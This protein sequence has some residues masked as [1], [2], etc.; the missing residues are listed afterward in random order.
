MGYDQWVEETLTEFKDTYADAVSLGGMAFSTGPGVPN[1]IE[2]AFESAYS[3]A[4]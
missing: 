1:V 2:D 4:K 3:L